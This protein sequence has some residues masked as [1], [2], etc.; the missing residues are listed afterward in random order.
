MEK[1]KVLALLL[2]Q[3]YFIEILILNKLNPQPLHIRHSVEVLRCYQILSLDPQ[4]G[5]VRFR[6]LQSS[7]RICN[8]NL[9]MVGIKVS[10]YLIHL[11]NQ[12]NWVVHVFVL[13]SY[14]TTGLI[15]GFWLL[16]R[17]F[18]RFGLNSLPRILRQLYL[19]VESPGVFG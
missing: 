1:A 15:C 13:Y 9:R 12:L 7:K 14:V 16:L 6:V 2:R 8:L 4:L 17:N 11:V 5:A 3:R 10:V 19:Y 18:K